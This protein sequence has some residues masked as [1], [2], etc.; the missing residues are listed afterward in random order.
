M[1]IYDFISLLDAH[2]DQGDSYDKSLTTNYE[3]FEGES[4]AF[5]QIL[6]R[7]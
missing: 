2:L 3:M 1:A 5:Y 7:I 4:T 6:K